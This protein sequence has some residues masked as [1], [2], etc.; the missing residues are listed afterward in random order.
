MT[1]RS[2]EHRVRILVFILQYYVITI[3]N[4]IETKGEI[5][6]RRFHSIERICYQRSMYRLYIFFYIYILI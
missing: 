3:I 5:L 2:D 6:K 1:V 4:T